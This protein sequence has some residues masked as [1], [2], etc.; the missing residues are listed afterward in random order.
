MSKRRAPPA[1]VVLMVWLSGWL[2]FLGFG[3]GGVAQAAVESPE[4]LAG[5]AAYHDLDYERATQLLQKALRTT[6]TREERLAAYKTL[7]F[8]YFALEKFDP[9]I[10]AFENVLR[11]DESFEL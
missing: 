8:S 1:V 4:V 10:D 6:L 9:A 5:I 11:I 3:S 7:A 2:A